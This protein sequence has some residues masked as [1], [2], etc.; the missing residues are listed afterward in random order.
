VRQDKKN[1]MTTPKPLETVL[2]P[3]MR[4]TDRQGVLK[5]FQ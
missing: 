4:L 2:I 1:V 3:L 5:Q